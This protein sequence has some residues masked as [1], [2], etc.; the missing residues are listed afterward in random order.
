M[1]IAR[2]HPNP[3]RWDGAECF[4]SQF[5]PSHSPFQGTAKSAHAKKNFQQ[6][7]DITI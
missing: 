7:I 3:F 5:L 4:L 2:F 6:I 1:P